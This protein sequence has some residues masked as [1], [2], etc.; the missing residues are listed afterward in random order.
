MADRPPTRVWW[1]T[2]PAVVLWVVLSLLAVL[3]ALTGWGLYAFYS[4]DNAAGTDMQVDSG[5]APV[6]LRIL[7]TVGMTALLAL[8]VVVGVWARHQWLGY[9]L[10]G[11]V[12][13]LVVLLVG[14]AMFGIV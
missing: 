7:A 14:L 8:S 1:S 4:F 3:P 6:P 12:L 9:F 5:H 2:W 13:V 11:I 10:L